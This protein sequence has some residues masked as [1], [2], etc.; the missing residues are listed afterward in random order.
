MTKSDTGPHV[1]AMDRWISCAPFERLL[2]MRIEEA[3]DGRSILKMPFS[4]ELAQGAGLMHGG[5]LLS[6]ADTATVMAI[7]SIVE[8]G[9][10]FG[11]I[12]LESHFLRP[13]R[14][15]T[16]TALAEVT[17]RVERLLYGRALVYDET[18]RVV[19]EATSTFKIAADATITAVTFKA[20]TLSGQKR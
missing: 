11:T 6:L 12:A 1:F 8:P 13:V 15:G 17:K 14:S 18:D 20:M 10:H 4:V 5:A 16:V 2:G 9:T 7:K 3:A 19:L